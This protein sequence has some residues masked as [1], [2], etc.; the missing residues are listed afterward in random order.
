MFR[1]TSKET[2]VSFNHGNSL[3]VFMAL[4][5][6]DEGFSYELYSDY[7]LQW[8]TPALPKNRYEELY[9]IVSNT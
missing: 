2:K 9:K 1:F 6:I 3:A 7:M 5:C 4:E 8:P